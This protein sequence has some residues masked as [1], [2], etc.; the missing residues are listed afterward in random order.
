[1]ETGRSFG[2]PVVHWPKFKSH[3]LLPTRE[4]GKCSLDVC[5]ER[6]REPDTGK[7][8][9]S[10]EEGVGSCDPEGSL[11]PYVQE[12]LPGPGLSHFNP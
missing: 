7:N 5:R 8:S 4:T 6:E 10:R 2:R 11:N 9:S 12:C 1:M 3:P